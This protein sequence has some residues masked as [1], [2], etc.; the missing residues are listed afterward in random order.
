MSNLNFVTYNV[1]GINNPIKRKKIISQL[2]KLDCSV[3]LLQETHLDDKEH[4]KLKREWIG[5]V[6]S[7]SYD[8]G[9]KR[10]VAILCH[11]NVCFVPETIYDDGKGRVILVVGT[12][13][14][15]YLT[16]LNLYAPNEED[17]TFFIQI[18]SILA[19]N[20]KGMIIVGG[21]YNAVVNQQTDR[22]PSVVGPKSQKTKALCGMLGELGLVDIWR[23]KHPRE[24]DFT[25]FSRVHK[26][27]SR[28]DMFCVSKQDAHKVTSCHIEP[29]TISDHSPVVM[30][31]NVD[32]DKRHKYWRLN[33]SLLNDPDVVQ[34]IKV[35]IKNYLELNDN[36]E[37][38]PS[39]L[40]EA[41][42]VVIRGKIIAI[43]SGLK[44][45]REKKQLQLEK[46]IKDLEREHKSSGCEEVLG[47]LDQYRRELNHLLTFKAEGALRF[48]SQKY[49]ESGNRASR[50]L[51]FQ[52]RKAQASRTV[53]KVV[54]P[55]SNSLVSH[56]KDIARAFSV[57]YKKLYDSPTVE[58]KEEKIRTLMEKI[59]LPKLSEEESQCMV[60]PITKEEI[61]EVI[62]TLKNNKSPGVDGFSGEF[63][64]C[65]IKE[66]SPLL[67]RVFNYALKEKDPPKSWS[68]AIITVIHKEGK[69]PTF[70]ASYRPISLLCNDVK[71]LSSIMARR[72]QKCI[73]KVISPD[74]TGF[75]PGR[76]GIHNIRRT[77]NVMSIARKSKQTSMLL[78]LDAEKAFDRLD[79][80]YLE[81]ALDK[82]GFHPILIDWIRV[83][84]SGPVSKVRVNGYTSDQFKLMR[85]ARQGCPLSP[86]LF[87]INIEVLA[88]LIRGNPNI[89]GISNSCKS[90][91]ISLYADDV[92][93][94]ISNPLES[95]PAI[96]DCLSEFGIVSGYK[97]NESKSEAMMLVGEFPPQLAGKVAFNWSSQG[98]RYLGIKITPDTSNLYKA[99]YGRLID[100]IKS[101]LARWEILPLSLFGRIETIR[102]NILPRLL[103]LFQALPVWIP[104]AVFKS[105]DKMMSTFIWQKRKP[106]I[107]WKMLSYP[108]DQGGL[109]LPNLKHYY[110]AAQLN[111]MVEW[112]KQDNDTNWLD[113]ERNSCPRVP[114]E[115]L[116]SLELKKWNNLRLNNEWMSCT[117]KVWSL[118]RKKFKMSLSI[119]RATR[120]DRNEDFLPS[121]LDSGFK[122]WTEK[123]LV[124]IHQ[125]LEGDSMKSFKQLQDRFGLD[126]KDFYKYLQ[127]RSYLLS[128]K[129]WGIIRQPPT[130][131][132]LFLIRMTEEK[133]GMKIISQIYSCL[134]SLASGNTLE[135]KAKW[136]LEMTVIIEDEEW[137][138]ACEVGHKITNSPLWKEFNWK[139]KMR[140]FR[141]PFMISKFDKNITDLCWRDCKQ[142]GDHTHIFWDCPKLKTY[143]EGIR[144]EILAILKI[145]LPLDPKVYIFGVV[146]EGLASNCVIKI[147]HILLLTARKMITLSWL[148]PL[149]P[150]INQW[151]ERLLNVYNME[152]ITAK[153]QMKYDMFLKIWVPLICHLNL[154]I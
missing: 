79:W 137:E 24:R 29:I 69:D 111:G 52:L 70:C 44:K 87:A 109:N 131:L 151:H 118:V 18:A 148:R 22:R 15:L 122:V 25:F 20:A 7:A 56:P 4:K 31:V 62:K 60:H 88:E 77:L 86:L 98:F 108:K 78:S 13:G 83:L 30:T 119:S 42:K 68:E 59:S 82:M 130:P 121:K 47:T 34:K 125:L 80:Q 85:G 41:A 135:I 133:R 5:Q 102:M 101:D 3:A 81:H 106:R 74:Q 66:I 33:V 132:E 9:K 43:S 89:S 149:P 123:G 114:L 67:Q 141:T 139:L 112:I 84:Y 95:I 53:A 142:I 32:S 75:M 35:E 23:L 63:Y 64:K 146:P 14:N 49:Y 97:V 76:Q 154:P 136:E 144:K 124:T 50:L 120:L 54:D 38:S 126:S 147:L 17:P 128:H 71:I 145:D 127:L 116:P 39:I 134:Q 152:K 16:I 46:N 55:V 57:F 115:S 150:T 1:K 21:D 8:K 10:G 26:S 93:L 27:H 65:F 153:L 94:Y 129:D 117:Y 36:G 28:I 96:M 61:E 91:V 143:W 48:T 40:W 107:K 19:K 73:T 105:L 104:A 51:A 92:I 11:K 140:Y 113:L 37:V 100:Q 12:I 110:W 45:E 72:I 99:N 103:F 138:T 90:H 6:F 58:N 2:K